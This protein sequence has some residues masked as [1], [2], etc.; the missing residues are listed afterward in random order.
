MATSRRW[1]FTEGD[2]LSLF[3]NEQIMPSGHSFTPD[4]DQTPST[5]ETH[6]PNNTQ[7]G[8]R[9]NENGQVTPTQVDTSGH[10]RTHAGTHSRFFLIHVHVGTRHNFQFFALASSKTSSWTGDTSGRFFLHECVLF[11]DHARPPARHAVGGV[12]NQRHA[13]TG[14]GTGTGRPHGCAH[15]QPLPTLTPL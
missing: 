9:F 3:F 5:H 6:T 14:T 8:S 2:P 10:T 12:H 4:G 15:H 13:G 7:N 11:G 1:V